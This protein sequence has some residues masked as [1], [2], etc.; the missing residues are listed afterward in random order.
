VAKDTANAFWTF[1]EKDRAYSSKDEIRDTGIYFHKESGEFHAL[2]YVK[3]QVK[4]VTALPKKLLEDDSDPKGLWD[5]LEGHLV[6]YQKRA[7]LI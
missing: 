5:A 7:G 2:V 6:N 4:T 3:Q 1:Y